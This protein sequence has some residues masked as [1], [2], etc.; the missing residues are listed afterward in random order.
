MSATYNDIRLKIPFIGESGVG[1]T[2]LI[3]KLVKPEHT[4]RPEDSVGHATIGIAFS[5]LHIFDDNQ[6]SISIHIWDTAGQERFNACIPLFFRESDIIV[7]MFDLTQK[8]SFESAIH[9]WMPMVE[10]YC[11]QI[12]DNGVISSDEPQQD[13]DTTPRGN[14]VVVLIGNKADQWSDDNDNHV[15]QDEIDEYCFDKQLVF[16]PISAN[17]D[18]RRALLDHCILTPLGKYKQFN[19]DYIKMRNKNIVQLDEEPTN[20]SGC[21][22][23]NKSHC[24]I[25]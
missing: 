7:V 8:D 1:K 16:F 14:T 22:T 17:I 23:K 12:N 21:F 25:L 4:V 2:S 10:R 3:Y 11:G 24:L 19:T 15:T 20:G 18:T 9:K 5:T 13:N 6:D